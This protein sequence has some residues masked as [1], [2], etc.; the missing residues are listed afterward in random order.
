MKHLF[1]RFFRDLLGTPSVMEDSKQLRYRPRLESLEDR[2]VPADLN[3]VALPL[4]SPGMTPSPSM[5]DSE[6]SSNTSVRA[7]VRASVSVNPQ[8]RLFAVGADAGGSPIVNVYNLN[9]TIRFSFFAFNQNFAGG[10]R[11]ATGDINFDGVDDIICAPGPGGTSNIRAFSGTNLAVLRNFFAFD[12]RFFG[13]AFVAC[14][15]VN[16]DLLGDIIVGADAGGGPA[17]R[18]FSGLG[19][20]MLRDFFAYSQFF[21]GGVRVGSGD[22]NFDGRAEIITGAGPGGAPHVKAFDALTLNTLQSFFAFD[23]TY[24]GGVFVSGGDVNADARADFIVGPGTSF[25]GTPNVRIFS[26]PNLTLLSSLILPGFPTNGGIRVGAEDLFG[27]RVVEV[28][29]GTGPPNSPFVQIVNGL[30]GFIFR[31]FL[32]FPQNFLGG[33]FV[34]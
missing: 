18:V 11:V 17:V 26:G 19:N 15:D 12:T 31:N 34:G 10:V 29:V 7:P 4:T 25:V 6:T 13:G 30:N 33:V 9:G 1:T 16:G 3:V 28:I 32:A 5:D 20:F 14:E 8:I 24:A 2:V 21:S 27:D 22:I 23:A